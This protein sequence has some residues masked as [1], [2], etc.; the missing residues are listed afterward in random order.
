MA[1]KACSSQILPFI[2]PPP[3]FLP[4]KSM[5][6][7]VWEQLGDSY[8]TSSMALYV[9]KRSPIQ[10]STK[11]WSNCYLSQ[12]KDSHWLQREINL[13]PRDYEESAFRHTGSQHT[14]LS[15][16]ND[17]KEMLRNY[18]L[19]LYVSLRWTNVVMVCILIVLEVN[20]E[21]ERERVREYV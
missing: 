11:T 10:G 14:K 12:W 9:K 8:W 3:S 18:L 17:F 4:C 16:W 1:R 5:P 13:A 6:D 20:T 15:S 2:S 7:F 19:M 21:G